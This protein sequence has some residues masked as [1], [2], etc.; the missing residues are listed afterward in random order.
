MARLIHLKA[1]F[2]RNIKNLDL[3][4]SPKVNL[5]YGDNGSGKSSLLEMI[6]CLGRGRS[7]RTHLIQPII[8]YQSSYCDVFGS[9]VSSYFPDINVGFK[10]VHG[11]KTIFRVGPD[12][13]KA[14]FSE[15]AQL[16]PLQLIHPECLHQFYQSTQYRRQFIDWG[17]FHVEPKFLDLWKRFHQGLKRRNLALKQHQDTRYVS[18]WDPEIVATGE[19]LANLRQA[20][21]KQFS[22]I[23]THF[24]NQFLKK[25]SITLMYD[26]GWEPSTDLASLLSQRIERDLLRGFT[27]KGPHRFNFILKIEGLPVE[28]VLS[29]GE[30][31]RLIYALYFAQSQLIKTLSHKECVYLLDDMLSELD[32]GYQRKLWQILIQLEAQVFVTT[33][34]VGNFDKLGFIKE[35]R[36]F[37]MNQGEVS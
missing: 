24:F 27:G 29:R 23:A 7:F 19:L 17:L 22:I 31:K 5:I 25:Y 32:D 1:N 36:R 10:K 35:D 9:L 12:H 11:Q 30:Q 4:F 6:Y 34:N 37:F 18:A 28:M 14:T 15:L 2:F 8:Q 33:I 20:Y 3:K 21:F 16:L 26:R 13:H